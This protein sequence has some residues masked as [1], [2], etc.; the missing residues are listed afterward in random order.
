MIC[1]NVVLTAKVDPSSVRV[2]LEQHT[3]HSRGELGCLRFDVHDAPT[4]P[5]TFILTERW[6]SQAAIDAHRGGTAYLEI[7]KPLV[8][9]RVVRRSGGNSV[10]FD[11][12]RTLTIHGEPVAAVV[13]MLKH[14]SA[15]WPV[16]IVTARNPAH[17]DETARNYDEPQRLLVSEAVREWSLP[18]AGVRFVNNQPK[19]LHLIELGCC[20]V[21]DD[22]TATRADATRHGIAAVDPAS[23]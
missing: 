14:H 12:D 10:A 15:Q 3:E 20:C 19:I 7:Y 18:V 17:D 23:L 1:H 4:M 8:L 5:D 2:C 13:A 6:E 16:W 21:V 11:F 22:C 9:P